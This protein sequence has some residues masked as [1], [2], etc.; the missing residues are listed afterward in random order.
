MYTLDTHAGQLLPRWQRTCWERL[1]RRRGITG[2]LEQATILVVPFTADQ[3]DAEHGG[4]PFLMELL[5]LT[6]GLQLLLRLQLQGK[7]ISDCQGLIRKLDK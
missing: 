2:N 1:H 4:F 5:G 7:V 3:L 6:G